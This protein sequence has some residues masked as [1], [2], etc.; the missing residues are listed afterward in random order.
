ME[1]IKPTDLRLK[2]WISYRGKNYQIAGLS[3]DYPFL[4]TIEFGVGVIEYPDIEPIPLTEE[5]LVKAG[6]MFDRLDKCFKLSPCFEVQIIADVYENNASLMFYTRTVHTDY[7]P[8]YKV[9]DT[10]HQFQNLYY[11]LTN[12]ELNIQL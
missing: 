12:E 2:N 4:D 5:I 10:V 8:I 9:I 3:K 1:A 6:F 7:K 11:S